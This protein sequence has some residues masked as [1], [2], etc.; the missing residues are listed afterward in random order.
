[1]LRDGSRSTHE[2]PTT[3]MKTPALARTHILSPTR[4]RPLIIA[5]ATALLATGC[6]GSIPRAHTTN[7]ASPAGTPASVRSSSVVVHSAPTVAVS[8]SYVTACGS[9]QDSPRRPHDIT[10][11]ADGTGGNGNVDF[12]SSS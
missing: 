10:V 4:T 9:S 6:G 11:E 1:M 5:A 3:S 12:G 2:H 8:L 7:P